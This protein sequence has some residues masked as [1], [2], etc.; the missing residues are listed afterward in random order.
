MKSFAEIEFETA[1]A[2]MREA[3]WDP[4]T[5]G[6]DGWDE[7]GK[8]LTR[9]MNT[10]AQGDRAKVCR[11]LTR[12]CNEVSQLLDRRYRLISSEKLQP[13]GVRSILHEQLSP[14]YK[15]PPMIAIK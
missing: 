5:H 9:L 15:V 13:E 4:Q 12:T 2:L 11:E 3:G 6:R 10:L 7:L 14:H 1:R 8:K